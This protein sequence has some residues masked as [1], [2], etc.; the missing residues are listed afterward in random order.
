LEHAA[1]PSAGGRAAPDQVNT[2]AAGAA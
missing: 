2:T 1:L